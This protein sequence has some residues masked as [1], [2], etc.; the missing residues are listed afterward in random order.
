MN[1]ERDP[2]LFIVSAPSGAGKTTLCNRLLAEFPNLTYSVSCT[3]RAP[4]ANEVDGESYTFITEAQFEERLQAG[5]FLEHARVHDHWYGTLRE[6]VLSTLRA[7]RNLLMDIDVQG[8]ANIRKSID[9]GASDEAGLLRRA[10]VDVFIAPPSLA[11]LSARLR[12]R[13]SDK[14]DVIARR[15]AFARRE[16]ELS[17]D[18]QYMI[19]NDDLERA[20]SDLRAIYRAEKC[21]R[22]RMQPVAD[23]L[24][25]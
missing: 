20:Y 25:Q 6:T 3:T 2:L 4:R 11:T 12:E 24:L 1:T 23:Q 13:G 21:R 9:Q 17:T 5:A 15:L 7:G 18:Y 8:T 10:Y 22:W 16:I 14:P 19:I